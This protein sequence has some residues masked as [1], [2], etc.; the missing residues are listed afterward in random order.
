MPKDENKHTLLF[1]VAA[2][3]A[4]AGALAVPLSSLLHRAYIQHRHKR[5]TRFTLGIWMSGDARSWIEKEGGEKLR[6]RAREGILENAEEDY[7]PPS[8]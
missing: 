3:A 4:T 6:W 5:H 1:A 8:D 2:T 7:R